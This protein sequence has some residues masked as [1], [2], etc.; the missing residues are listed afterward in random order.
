MSQA[1]HGDVQDTGSREEFATKSTLDTAAAS[2]VGI[3]LAKDVFQLTFA[4]AAHRVQERKRLTRTAF[5]REL[6]QR[7]SLHA[8][9]E[10]CGS[11]HDSARLFRR[12]RP[13]RHA[14]AGTPSQTRRAAPEDR[15][16]R[17][18]RSARSTVLR[19]YSTR[20]G[21]D[22]GATGHPDA[23]IACANTT[24]RTALRRST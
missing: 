12:A 17:C 24:R 9:M 3:D 23:C 19:R 13:P 18:G 7:P 10:A 4:N 5:A 8:V 1:E 20:A 14:A 16:H 22:T 21:Q 11:A 15:P 6:V 2:I